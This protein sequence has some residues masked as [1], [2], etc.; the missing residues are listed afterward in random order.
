[1]LFEL[2][3]QTTPRRSIANYMAPFTANLFWDG[4]A[5]GLFIDPVTGEL[6]SA[7]GVAATEIQSLMPLMNDVEM[8]HQD[9]DWPS[10]LN[11]LANVRPLALASDIP[12]DMLDALEQYP[13]YPELFEQAFGTPEITAGRIGF[14][15]ANYQRTL[16]PDQTPW[17]EWNAGDDSA[18]TT[19]QL[20]GC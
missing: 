16:V 4:R 15:M 9:R 19:D 7:T 14:A 8:A 2:L 20:A 18:M 3:P 11:K 1:M 12:Q 6:L 13:T 10:L 5:E 17:D